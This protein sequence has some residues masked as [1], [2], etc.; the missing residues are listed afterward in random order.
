MESEKFKKL[1]KARGHWRDSAEDV[2]HI[3]VDEGWR[4]DDPGQVVSI[5]GAEGYWDA[6]ESV[7]DLTTNK[8]DINESGWFLL[9]DDSE[10]TALKLSNEDFH[11]IVMQKKPTIFIVGDGHRT[12]PFKYAGTIQPVIDAFDVGKLQ[13]YVE[14]SHNDWLSYSK[15]KKN[16]ALPSVFF[17][18][19]GFWQRRSKVL[20]T[21]WEPEISGVVAELYE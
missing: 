2:A 8:K 11:N 5:K 21:P 13:L 20:V 12:P 7:V 18:K 3:R 14:F 6:G 15:R 10:E 9:V 16:D 4:V 17:E 1:M 19:R